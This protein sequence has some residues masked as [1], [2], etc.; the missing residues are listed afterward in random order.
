LMTTKK[1]SP[2]KLKK[3]KRN[4]KLEQKQNLKNIKSQTKVWDFS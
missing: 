3:V 1:N 2:S 4:L